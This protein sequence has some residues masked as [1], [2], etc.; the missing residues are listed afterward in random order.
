VGAAVAAALAAADAVGAADAELVGAAPGASS[1]ER[2]AAE[3]GAAGSVAVTIVG[4]D[5]SMGG[6]VGASIVAAGALVGSASV[7]VSS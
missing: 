6:A 3:L 4:G 5:E 1:P 7:F 2:A